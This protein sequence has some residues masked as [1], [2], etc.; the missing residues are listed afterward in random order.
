[1]SLNRPVGVG[2]QLRAASVGGRD[3]TRTSTEPSTFIRRPEWSSTLDRP[4]ELRAMY[5]A[6]SV[7]VSDQNAFVGGSCP[8]G[9]CRR[10]VCSPVSLFVSL[11]ALVVQY[12]ASSNTLTTGRAF[13]NAA[14]TS[15]PLPGR[16]ALRIEFQPLTVVVSAFA[17]AFR[18]RTVVRNAKVAPMITPCTTPESA[19]HVKKPLMVGVYSE[20][21]AAPHDERRALPDREARRFACSVAVAVGFEPTEGVNP[22]TLSRRAPSAART[23]YRRRAYKTPL[24]APHR[25][26]T[27]RPADRGRWPGRRT[28]R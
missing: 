14:R 22:H 27:G 9:K 23:R 8:G 28:R 13:C 1:M 4:V 2:S 15:K 25:A 6:V 11:S 24:T 19:T 26:R 10:Y 5:P 18:M 12:A 16:P 7:A 3:R 17:T 20:S 21:G